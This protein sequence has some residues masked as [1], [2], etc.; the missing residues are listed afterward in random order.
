MEN[1][2]SGQRL[3]CA[4]PALLLSL[5]AAFLGVEPA[6]GQGSPAARLPPEA[7]ASL[8]AIELGGADAE[9]LVKGSWEASLTAQAALS[10]SS[11]GTGL[12]SIQPLLFSQSPD[13]FLSFLLFKKYF[14]EA[15]VADDISQARYSFGYRGGEDETLEELKGG[16]DGISFP[17]LPFLSFGEGSYRSFGLAAKARAKDFSG[18]AMLRYDQAQRASKRYSGGAELRDTALGAQAFLRGRWFYSPSVPCVNLA[19]YAESLSGSFEGSDGK[20]YRPLEPGEYSYSST[21]GLIS[22]AR[23]SATRVAARYDGYAGSELSVGGSACA[24]LYDPEDLSKPRCQV[25]CRYPSSADPAASE[26]FVRDAATGLKD[27]AY[28]VILGAGYAELR[29]AGYLVAAGSALDEAYARPFKGDASAGLDWIYVTDLSEDGPADYAPVST[30]DIVIRQ[31]SPVDAMRIDKDF[32]PGSVEVRRDGAPEYAF[33]VDPD[34][35][36]VSLASPPGPYEVIDISYLRESAERKA[37]SV[38]AGLGGLWKLGEGRN[39]WAALGLRWSLPGIGYGAADAANPGSLVLT[40]G[41]KDAEGPFTHRAALAASYGRDETS[42]RYRIEGME[43]SGSFATSFRPT[44]STPEGFTAVETL[45]SDL[46]KSFPSL[47]SNF[48]RDGS[49]QQALRLDASASDWSVSLAKIIPRP[50]YTSFEGLSFFV[51]TSAAGG[52]LVLRLDEGEGSSA[53]AV[54]VSVSLAALPAGEWRRIVV[55]YGDLRVYAQSSEDAELETVGLISSVFDPTSAASRLVIEVTGAG[56]GQVLWIDEVTLEGSAGDQAILFQGELAWSRPDLQAGNDSSPILRGL[57]LKSDLSA[58]L[59]E[60]S[61]AAGGASLATKL[62]PIELKLRA[63]ARAAAGEGEGPAASGGHD[64]ALPAGPLPLGAADHFDFDPDTGAFGKQDRASLEAG[65]ALGI[66]IAQRSSWIPP[67]SAVA[68]ILSQEWAGKIAAAGGRLS[69]EAKATNR[70]R[71]AEGPG[72]A[73]AGYLDAWLDSFAYLLPAFEASSDRRGESLSLSAS[74]APAAEII[75]AAASVVAE[76]GTSGLRRN[77]A[78]VKASVPLAF[79]SLKVAPYYRRAWTD[80]RTGVGAGVLGDLELAL[81]D[82]SSIPP[83]YSPLFFAELAGDQAASDFAAASGAAGPASAL[84]SPETG[85]VLSREYGSR[86]Y[87][88]LAPSALSLAFRR[89]LGRADAS[90]TDS[91][92]WILSSMTAALN[93]FGSQGS[94][95]GRLPFES[96]EYLGSLQATIKNVARESAPRLLLQAQHLASFV[97]GPDRLDAENRTY[98]STQPAKSDWSE[99]LA[100]NLSRRVARHW[101]LDLYGLLLPAKAAAS[102]GKNAL[103]SRYLE[104]LRSR[105]PVARSVIGLKAAAKRAV[106]D[107]A[108]PDATWSV[109]E[110]YEAKLTVPER[111]TA[112]V[113]ASLSQGRDGETGTLSFGGSLSVGLALSF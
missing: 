58:A 87:D 43:S 2:R 79:G 34:L 23:E 18:R 69:L 62:G 16:N 108:A 66:D 64:L 54:V 42:D 98:I 29:R 94:Y 35:G 50:S 96:D 27:A 102:G 38:A 88:L 90:L 82:F 83:F 86:W 44:G 3:A 70:A 49:S 57:E 30:R 15:R 37:G 73:G 28:E 8:L 68:G 80:A 46:K 17:E 76:P 106:T 111:L 26:A 109:E 60:T 21:T 53:K 48:H 85:L 51:K 59:R 4:A 107:A 113:K 63:R 71:P 72:L 19:L 1:E 12:S 9:L 39:A 40:A 33:I 47:V 36:T 61:Y 74:L 22:L 14:V 52:S 55:K 45:E 13:L 100:F 5:L 101:L 84:Y 89:E 93:L 97:S 105:K 78:A 20:R 99:S 103:A 25:L 11:S 10:S 24:L 6:S 91:G 95:P 104:E 67:S 65:R 31:R 92:S 110:R 112:T 81:G 41:E 7:P 56:A 77:S 75:S 32:I